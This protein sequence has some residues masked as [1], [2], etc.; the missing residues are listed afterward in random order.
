[1][2]PR[3]TAADDR[4]GA[5]HPARRSRRMDLPGPRGRTLAYVYDSG[6]AD[7]DAVGLEALAMFAGV[8][9]PRPDGLPLARC[10]WRTTSSRWPGGLLDAPDGFAGSVTSGGTES[11]LLAVL[12]ARKGAA[13]LPTRAWSCPPRRTPR[14]TR[15]PS[16]SGSAPCSSTS[17][18]APCA[19]IRPRWPPPSTTPTV[20]VVASAPSYA[21]GVVDPVPEIAALAAERGIRCHVDACIGGWVLPHLDDAPPVDLRGRGRH[22]RQRR[23]A[24]VRLHP[25]G[26]LG[27]A[28]PHRR[29]CAAPTSSPRRTGPATRCSTARCSRRGRAARSPRRGPSPTGSASRGMPTWPARRA[30]RPSRSRPRRRHPGSARAG[31]AGLDPGRPGHRRLVRRLHHRRRDARAGAGSPSRRCPSATCRRRCT[32]RCR[33]PPPPSVP[34]LVEALS[35][36]RRR[37][38]RRRSGQPSTPVSRRS[39][40][41]IDPGDPRRRRLRRAPRRGGARGRRRSPRPARADGARQRPPRRLPAATARGPPARRPRPPVAPD[42]R[43]TRRRSACPR[44]PR[45][46]GWGGSSTAAGRTPDGPRDEHPARPRSV[47]HGRAPSHRSSS[48]PSATTSTPR[49]PACP[50]A[51]P[52]STARAASG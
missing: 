7:A 8:Q 33:P 9:R 6:L 17:T 18:P 50:T 46:V 30:R 16:S 31:A 34:E 35:R 42:A 51:T 21:H 22:E 29:P 20:L 43:L 27:A 14:S 40:R 47:A 41:R 28:A 24:Q 45:R 49:S 44:G 10:G 23:P 3:L 48:R 12:A 4:R 32:S 39:S 25:Q 1:M 38:P 13:R 36:C 19:P 15:R 5:R 37:R 11:I 2:T 52:S 26:R